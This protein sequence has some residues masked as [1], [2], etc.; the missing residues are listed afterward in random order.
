MDKQKVVVIAGPTASG[1]TKLGVYLAK[2]FNGE[3]I[4]ADSMQIYKG[5]QI[6]SAKPT[7]EEQEGIPH[8]LMDFLS[9]ENKFSVADFVNLASEKID[10]ISSRGKLP[11]VVGGTGLYIDSL[12]KNFHFEE[13]EADENYRLQLL[14]KASK[15]NNP[16]EYLFSL[17]KEKDLD[18]SQKVHPNN[19]VKVVR[20]LEVMKNTGMS[21][22]E[23]QETVAKNEQKYKTLK[24]YLTYNDREKLYNRINER[25]EQMFDEGLL[26]EAKG[27]FESS[28]VNQTAKAAI[29]Y[30]ELIGYFEGAI[31]LQ[32][33]KED[34]QQN[35]RRYAKRQ[36]TWF[37]R[38]QDANWLAV[39]S[40]NSN[41]LLQKAK[42]YV[43]NFLEQE[44]DLYENK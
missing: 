43:T 42:E 5:F 16:Q 21:M 12:L 30:K 10:E 40:L 8:H 17:L 34:I 33:A 27:V 31:H 4:S 6:L 39:D 19:Q 20:A 25:V 18:Y 44:K 35:T 3:I 7:E 15:T 9:V 36:L 1:K 23:Y 28:T 32:K 2:E 41:D 11:I 26:Y 38:S 37:R 13:G 29:G 24:I 14:Q 22:T